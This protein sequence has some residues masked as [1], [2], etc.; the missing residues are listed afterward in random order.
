[1]VDCPIFGRSPKV[2]HLCRVQSCLLFATT[3]HYKIMFAYI[4]STLGC[5]RVLYMHAKR[6]RKIVYLFSST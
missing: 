3:L 1:M 5:D 2:P 4:M 6:Q